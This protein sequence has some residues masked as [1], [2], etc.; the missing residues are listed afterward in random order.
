MTY[1]E[2][3]Q[4]SELI[5]ND[6]E[7]KLHARKLTPQIWDLD[8]SYSW[9]ETAT[10]SSSVG[11]FEVEDVTRRLS[12]RLRRRDSEAENERFDLY[13]EEMSAS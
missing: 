12:G 9:R 4:V 10:F 5:A 6:A 3:H 8:G 11:S 13:A 7:A 2:L 1:E